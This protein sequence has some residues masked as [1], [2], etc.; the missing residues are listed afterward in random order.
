[1]KSLRGM[2]CFGGWGGE[3]GGCG[4]LR[5]VASEGWA[6]VFGVPRVWEQRRHSLST[7]LAE[8]DVQTRGVNGA[9]VANPLWGGGLVFFGG[10]GR[11]RGRVDAGHVLLPGVEAVLHG[12]EVEHREG[13]LKVVLPDRRRGPAPV[14][15]A[16]SVIG[17]TGWRW[18][19][20]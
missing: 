12:G 3:G 15:R 6:L 7:R 10:G 19:R 20:Q 4:A 9:D 11:R 17:E 8:G 2:T 13:L 16:T 18:G 1:M 14:H 5:G